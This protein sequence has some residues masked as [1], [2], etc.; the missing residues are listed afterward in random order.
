[1]LVEM[2]TV[3]QAAK[4][5]TATGGVHLLATKDN[6]MRLGRRV[7]VGRDFEVHR[8]AVESVSVLFKLYD[9]SDRYLV[10]VPSGWRVTAAKFE[11]EWPKDPSLVHSHFGARRFAYNWALARVKA[12]MDAKSEDPNHIS[13][14][15][16]LPELRKEWNR[17]KNEA[18]PWWATNSKES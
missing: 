4:V 8:E 15:W 3:T 6:E 5:A 12:D 16:T 14:P 11:V 9:H 17:V 2:R 7:D 13:L 10:E 1:M 18:A